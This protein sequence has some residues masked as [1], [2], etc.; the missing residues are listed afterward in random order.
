[1]YR[2]FISVNLP[3]E[4]LLG[5]TD[6]QNSLKRQLSSAPLRW[7]RAQ[8]IHLT[9]KFLGDT[10]PA[11]ID[12]I[13]AGLSRAFEQQ[14]AF[15]I[16]IGGLDGFPNTRNPNVLW[17]GVHDDDGRLRRLAADVDAAMSG[18]GW[19]RQRRPF[20]GHLTLARVQKQA[21]GS[22]RRALGE[23]L[24]ALDAPADLGTLPVRQ[25]HLMRSQLQPSGSIY[26]ALA[27]INIG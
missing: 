4:L 5:L 3:P 1:M 7:S 6:L 2:L 22:E 26:T 11:R 13:V 19:Q 17:V 10:D 9:L 27:E 20:S 18:L 8:G 25:I 16:D 24:A 14:Q 23:R 12:S 15:E 21:G